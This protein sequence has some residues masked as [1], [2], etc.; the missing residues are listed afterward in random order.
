MSLVMCCFCSCDGNE[1]SKLSD[2]QKESRETATRNPEFDNIDIH[3]KMTKSEYKKKYKEYKREFRNDDG[4]TKKEAEKAFSKLVYL[5]W[6]NYTISPTKFA[7][8]S[9][10]KIYNYSV[11][12]ASSSVCDGEYSDMMAI[13]K[14]DTNELKVLTVEYVD[15]QYSMNVQSYNE[16]L[17]EDLIEGSYA[18]QDSVLF[19]MSYITFSERD[20]A[21]MNEEDVY[22]VQYE[23]LAWYGVIFEDKNIQSYI[24]DKDWYYGY[25]KEKK[26]D[27]NVLTE[28]QRANL[29]TIRE[30]LKHEEEKE[31]EVDYWEDYEDEEEYDDMDDLI[32]QPIEY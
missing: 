16:Y 4:Y 31:N 25:I 9:T 10:G 2:S 21:E 27:E 30:Y 24:K 26:F 3:E 23:L 19:D 6:N 15:G 17:Q 18:Y 13:I 5:E 11:L 7:V 22:W 14:L 8:L 1:L 12:H 32:A 28:C 29:K 20:I